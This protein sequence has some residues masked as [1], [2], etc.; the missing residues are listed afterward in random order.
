MNKY[1]G[2]NVM[3][4]LFLFFLSFGTVMASELPAELVWS[5]RLVLSTTVT[6][7]V[8]KVLVSPGQ[9]LKAGD[10]ILRLDAR[11]FKAARDQA[12]AQ[13]LAAKTTYDEA[14]RE[15]H[16]SQ[17]LFDRTMLSEHE[18][19]VAR[20]NEAQA[21]AEYLRVKAKLL[22][23]RV[24]FERSRIQAPFDSVLLGVMAQSG[25]TIVSSL[26]A[27]PLAVVAEA[28]RMIARAWLTLAE[29]EKFS[30]A[31]AQQVRVN[32]R[33]FSVVSQGIAQEANAKGLYAMDVLFEKTDNKLRAGQ[34]ASIIFP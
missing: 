18:L 28:D 12:A 22:E 7:V 15:L 3:R 20:N 1:V 16:R 9:V 10:V 4:S 2:Q 17:E 34:T 26:R 29:I 32:G 5:K 23:T 24:A 25:Q 8:D 14:K 19:Q 33:K 13:L 27:E 11:E 21:K 30:S 6:G 31:K